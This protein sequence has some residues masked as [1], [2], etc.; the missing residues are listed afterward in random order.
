MVVRLENAGAPSCVRFCM[1]SA[2][3]FNRMGL[4]PSLGSKKPGGCSHF[5]RRSRNRRI[6]SFSGLCSTAELPILADRLGFEPRTQA[7]VEVTD[8][9]HRRSKFQRSIKRV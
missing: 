3:L 1:W 4:A 6:R 7:G 8:T 2:G 9:L 5:G